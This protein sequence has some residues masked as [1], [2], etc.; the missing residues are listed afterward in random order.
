MLRFRWVLVGNEQPAPWIGENPRTGGISVDNM[1]GYV[2]HSSVYVL[3]ESHREPELRYVGSGKRGY[4]R[5]RLDAGWR[6]LA[7]GEILNCNN[8]AHVPRR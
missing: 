7:F 8:L 5:G 2:H 3:Y 6:A 1:R 4:L